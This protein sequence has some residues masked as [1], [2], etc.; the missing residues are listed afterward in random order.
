MNT[1]TSGRAT[2]ER[3]AD[4]QSENASAPPITPA[5]VTSANASRSATPTAD[6]AQRTRRR[7]NNVADHT[8]TAVRCPYMPLANQSINSDQH[9]RMLIGTLFLAPA[10]FAEQSPPL[11]CR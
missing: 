9:V 2:V 8:R 10:S 6:S 11:V 4:V 1:V 3:S 5:K 7:E